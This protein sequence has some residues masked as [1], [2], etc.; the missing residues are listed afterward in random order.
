MEHQL[1]LSTFVEYDLT[2][3]F[4]FTRLETAIKKG[5]QEILWI[6]QKQSNSL[7]LAH[8]MGIDWWDNWDVGD[9]TIRVKIWSY[10][11]RVRTNG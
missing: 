4:P 7:K 1:T 5:I 9:G 6:Y 2:W 3:E 10:R 11:K 8:E